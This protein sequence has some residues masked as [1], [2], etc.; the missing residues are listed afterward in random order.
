MAEKPSTSLSSATGPATKPK[1][2]AEPLT[3]P[4]GR[5][6]VVRGRLWR[7][8]N[9]SLPEAERARLVFNLMAARR[10]VKAAK[11]AA[12]AERLAAARAGV[13]A[14]KVG[15]GERGP[16]WWKDDAP[17]FNRT[18]VRNTPYAEWFAGLCPNFN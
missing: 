13:Q 10:E 16:V 11:A 12:D 8:S 7:R 6:I 17:D 5:Y 1:W 4:D 14:A 18:L 2:P 15:L 9:P 3:T